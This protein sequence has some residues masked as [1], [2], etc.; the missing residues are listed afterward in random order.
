MQLIHVA[1]QQKPTQHCHYPPIKKNEGKWC[2]LFGPRDEFFTCE[3]DSAGQKLIQTW[4]KCLFLQKETRVSNHVALKVCVWLDYREWKLEAG[5]SPEAVFKNSWNLQSECE[6]ADTKQSL[7]GPEGIWGANG[8]PLD[9]WPNVRG[10][11][12]ELKTEHRE[13]LLM[14]SWFLWKKW[15]IRFNLHSVL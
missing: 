9:G 6:G 3:N 15:L 11:E 10:S 5:M 12:T 8:V 2:V 1:L 14:E 4:K 7:P 13:K